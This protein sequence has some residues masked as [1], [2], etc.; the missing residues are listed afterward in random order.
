[1]LREAAYLGI[2]AYSVLEN[3]PGAVDLWLEK[4]GRARLLSR[5]DDLEVTPRKPL[6]R[7][8]SNPELLTQLAAIVA[9]GSANPAQA[10]ALER[11]R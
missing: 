5:A 3:P 8:D 1:M 11:A 6:G 10:P 2:P 4:I 9:Q 7:L